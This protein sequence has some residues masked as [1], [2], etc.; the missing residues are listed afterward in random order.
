MYMFQFIS[1]YF[2]IVSRRLFMNIIVASAKPRAGVLHHT[3]ENCIAG[4]GYFSSK[5]LQLVRISPG[6]SSRIVV[7][8]KYE[9]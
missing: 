5:L 2:K 6:H 4:E 7:V 8:R 1:M 9:L 3:L